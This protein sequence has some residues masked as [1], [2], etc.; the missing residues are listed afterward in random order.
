MEQ[1]KAGKTVD[2]EWF[3][4]VS[5]YFSDI[6]GFT[7]IS[8]GS[9]PIQV[10]GQGIAFS[11]IGIWD[12]YAVGIGK[13]GVKTDGKWDIHGIRDLDIMIKIGHSAVKYDGKRE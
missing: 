9:T 2:P 10:T 3:D 7:T 6:V 12:V 8:A 4:E 11:G 13:K 5:I 1:L